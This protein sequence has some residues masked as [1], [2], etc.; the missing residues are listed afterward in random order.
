MVGQTDTKSH[1]KRQTRRKENLSVFFQI[2]SPLFRTNKTTMARTTTTTTTTANTQSPLPS[3]TLIRIFVYVVAGTLV[4][5]F[6]F[7]KWAQSTTLR[8]NTSASDSF[9]VQKTNN[10]Y[11]R[12]CGGANRHDAVGWE[13]A[14]PTTYINHW[15]EKKKEKEQAVDKRPPLPSAAAVQQIVSSTNDTWFIASVNGGVWRSKN[16]SYGVHDID[17][18]N[19]D[20]DKIR[21][22]PSVSWEN[23][24]DGQPVTCSSMS[25][26]HVSQ[27]DPST[28]YAGC[29]GSTSS[30]QG[31]DHNVVNS[32]DWSGIMVSHD[33]GETWEMVEGFPENYYVTDILEMTIPSNQYNYDQYEYSDD[34]DK[35]QSTSS[36]ATPNKALHKVLLVS[37]QSH[38]WNSTDGG[39]WRSEDGGR[40]ERTSDIP[41]F[42]LTLVETKNIPI[43]Q[44]VMGMTPY[45]LTAG[46]MSILLATHAHSPNR[47]ASL[48][49]DGGL[50]FVDV[51]LPWKEGAVPFYTCA[52]QLVGGTIIVGGL[53]RLPNGRPNST[54]SQIFV[55]DGNRYHAGYVDQSP[56]PSPSTWTLLSTRSTQTLSQSWIDLHQPMRLDQDSM[57]KDRMA[58]MG[59]PEYD[60]LLYVAGNADALAW[61]VNITTGEWT[62][63]WDEPDVLDGSI[64]HGDCRNFAWDHQHDRLLLVSDGG[65]FARVNPRSPG[66]YWLSL[67]G[68]YSAFEFISAHYDYR[69]DR[70][71][72][73]AQDN[74]AIVT[75]RGAVAGDMGM[76]F[77]MGD[78]TVTMVDSDATPSRL[79]GTTQFLGVGTIENDPE[80][81]IS[82]GNDSDD[83]DGKGEDDDDDDDD[84]DEGCG[85][86]CFV[87]GD[88]FIQVPVEKYFPEPSSFPFFV[89]TYTLNRQD[90]SKL[91]F[92]VNSTESGI[93]EFD[94]DYT[95]NDK[96]DIDPPRKV[97]ST[98]KSE[99]IMDFVSGGVL[100]GV[101]DP[102][103][104]VAVSNSHLFFRSGGD[105]NLGLGLSA[106][107]LPVKYA[108]PVT[109]QY[110]ESQGK[111]SRI[112]GPLTHAR[113]VFMHVMAEDSRTIAITGWTTIESN[114]GDENIF[115][116]RDGGMHWDDIT[117]NLREASGVAGKVRPSGMQ[118]LHISSSDEEVLAILVGTGNGIFVT[119]LSLNS[120]AGNEEYAWVRYGN[121][122]EFPIVLVADIDHEPVT[123]RL[124]A[125]TYGRGIY[126]LKN[127]TNKL[128]EEFKRIVKV[129]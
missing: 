53:T 126:I 89:H 65:V 21:R 80:Q 98:P 93:F 115:L 2:L 117:G 54:D 25:V 26:L 119:Y 1:T 59:D 122:N 82:R 129:L 90:P 49:K 77:V 13:F 46:H 92:W 47:T 88:K 8:G 107:P 3:P 84:D 57:P 29:G 39:V 32:G 60:D 58:L 27:A 95:V 10:R 63:L 52:T 9:R 36:I 11:E 56:Q 64:P 22:H 30:E 81:S 23:V 14:G 123:D 75:K 113:T 68:N 106:R 105:D 62:K 41:T 79:F 73:G 55:L 87:Q 15:E 78:G 69:D 12:L 43:I 67:N 19:V 110:D 118:M 116:T 48:S 102:N 99:M 35:E 28:V 24:L 108:L 31:W 40:F 34:N 96:D 7:L 38:L 91:L 120:D 121:C 4:C 111:G 72:A 50:S 51:Q 20:G 45:P 61:R 97:V 18:E 101:A 66:G 94:I 42:T 128:H 86:L 103:L 44:K 5:L 76:G 33:V 109:L 104:I 6:C 70:Y 71:I 114:E 100:N 85:G 74:C 127:A 37:A 83:G 125:S 16:I 124:V 112:L 17:E